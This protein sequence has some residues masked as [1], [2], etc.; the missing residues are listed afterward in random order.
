MIAPHI[1]C[2]S[3]LNVT[4]HSEDSF[5]SSPHRYDLAAFANKPTDADNIICGAT[6]FSTLCRI[7][8]KPVMNANG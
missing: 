7:E 8:N 6:F 1:A 4:M 2:A 5:T 3:V